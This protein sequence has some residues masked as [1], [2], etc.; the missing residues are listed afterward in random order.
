[1]AKLDMS[2]LLLEILIPTFNRASDLKKNLN[3]LSKQ[4]LFDGL[5]N[6]ISISISDNCSEDDSQQIIQDFQ[7]LHPEISLNYNRNSSNIG[8]EPNVLQLLKNARA[9]YLLWLGDDDYLAEGY[10]KFVIEKIKDEKI[11][12]ILTGLASLKADGTRKV[13]RDTSTPLFEFGSGFGS[14]LEYSHLAHQMSG[15]VVKGDKLYE[16]YLKNEKWRNPYLFIFMAAD[17]LNR[18]NGI[19]APIFATEI[20]DFNPKDWGYNQV[21]LLDEVF[22]SYYPFLEELGDEKVKRLLIRFSVIHSYRYNIDKFH[23]IRLFS[24]YR[25]L[26]KAVPSINQFKKELAIHLFKDYLLSWKR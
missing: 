16:R 15:L 20:S 5:N 11:G 9:P 23:P 4:I 12:I 7:K 3:L 13:R 26:I 1:M 14:M 19:Y 10:L 8:L 25:S 24:Q 2:S 6:K 21:G 22:K 18:Y 17:C